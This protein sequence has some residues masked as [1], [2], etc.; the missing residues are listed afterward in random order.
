MDFPRH[1][2]GT[3]NCRQAGVLIVADHL[4]VKEAVSKGRPVAAQKGSIIILAE[5]GVLVG[6]KYSNWED[7][8]RVL[9]SFKG[10]IYSGDGVKKDGN[11][12]TSAYCPNAA[13]YYG[14]EDGTPELTKLFIEAIKE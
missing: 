1:E 11:I 13:K 8:T 2:N 14:E 12:V 3:F 10:A 6:A 5:A 9:G 7:H 4:L